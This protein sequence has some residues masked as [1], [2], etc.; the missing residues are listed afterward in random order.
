MGGEGGI[1]VEGLWP[2]RDGEGR[3]VEEAREG[4]LWLRRGREKGN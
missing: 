1:K 2:R 3:G 4:R